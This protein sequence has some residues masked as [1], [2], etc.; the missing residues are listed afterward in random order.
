MSYIGAYKCTP[1]VSAENLIP[2]SVST[3]V[4]VTDD[5]QKKNL[6]DS[7]V[8]VDAPGDDVMMMLMPTPPQEKKRARR[9]MLTLLQLLLVMMMMLMLPNLKKS[10]PNIPLQPLLRAKPPAGGLNCFWLLV[11][12]FRLPAGSA[13]AVVSAPAFPF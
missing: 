8:A 4:A 3:S 2:R 13:R 12:L 6:K 7:G 11:L 9:K 1:C 5:K 10:A